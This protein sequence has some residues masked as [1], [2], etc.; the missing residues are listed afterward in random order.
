MK[1]TKSIT[2]IAMASLFFAA[3]VQT[4][5]ASDWGTVGKVAVGLVVL[6]AVANAANSESQTVHQ[7]TYVRN[8]HYTH[9]TYPENSYY[10][11]RSDHYRYQQIP[12]RRYR[13]DRYERVSVSTVTT[14]GNESEVNTEEYFEYY[15]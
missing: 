8:K 15:E 6:G 5:Y 7:R 13:S 9:N 2:G 12:D 1:I 3:N 10:A 4:T 14:I 11:P